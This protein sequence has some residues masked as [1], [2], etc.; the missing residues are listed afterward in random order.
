LLPLV[1]MHVH[2]YAGLDDGPQTM[3]DAIEMCRIAVSEGIGSCAAVAHQSEQ[4]PEVTPDRIRSAWSKLTEALHKLGIPLSVFPSAEV[5]ACPDLV[6]RWHAGTLMSVADRGNYLLLELP[7]GTF[8]DV[9]QVVLEL[10]AGGIRP[11][12]AHAERTPELLHEP[13]IIEELVE[14][15]CL[16]Q[17]SAGSIVDPPNPK[18]AQALRDWFR[19]GVVHVLGS[20]GHSPR[21][22][23][24]KMAAAAAIVREWAGEKVAEA[25]CS[26]R[27]M[28]I[29]GG[30]PLRVPPPQPR[31]RKWYS[32]LLSRY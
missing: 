25:I 22:R 28:A 30:L 9:R 17:V 15:D 6:T 20:D 27:G 13:G 8:V 18:D 11:I 14:L 21:R 7:H 31:A 4:W 5:A 23:A 1:D 16:V 10:R 26:I 2:L 32:R 12:I 19:R 24:P 29:L 3:A